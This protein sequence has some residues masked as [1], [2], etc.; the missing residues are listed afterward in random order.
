MLFRSASE[1]D[2]LDEL[3]DELE[4]LL[5]PHPARSI[6]AAVVN[7]NTTAICFFNEF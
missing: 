7:A 1:L 2:E 6:V 3:D 4:S 5:P